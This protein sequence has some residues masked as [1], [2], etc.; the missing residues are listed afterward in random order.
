MKKILQKLSWITRKW[1]IEIELLKVMIHNHYREWGFN[2][3]NINCDLRS[4]SLLKLSVVLPNGAEVKRVMFE[5]DILFLRQ[6]LYRIYSDLSD[7]RMW[8]MRDLTFREDLTY[9]FLKY[10]FEFNYR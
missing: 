6:P 8:S 9:K 4:Y 10:I 7:Q 3:L 5:G 1:K 2:L